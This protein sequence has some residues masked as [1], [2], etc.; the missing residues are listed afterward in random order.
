MKFFTGAAAFLAASASACM[1][2]GSYS[3][4]CLSS[5]F[6]TKQREAYLTY[7]SL[8]R[9]HGYDMNEQAQQPQMQHSQYS[10]S[11]Y[12]PGENP[13]LG[14]WKLDDGA[15]W[16][17]PKDAAR[18]KE[19]PVEV[20]T[21]FVEQVEEDLNVTVDVTP[22]EVLEPEVVNAN[23]TFA[24]KIKML[25]SLNGYTGEKDYT[26]Y[27][28]T[29][30]SYK[31]Y[32]PDYY[33]EPKY[34][35]SITI[36]QPTKAGKVCLDGYKPKSEYDVELENQYAYYA[37]KYEAPKYEEPKY[38]EPCYEPKY[39]KS[40]E[41]M[42]GYEVEQAAYVAPYQSYKQPKYEEPKYEAP[43]YEK[44]KYVKSYEPKTGYEV[45]KSAY[46]YQQ[47]DYGYQQDYGYKQQDYG[48]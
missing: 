27:M 19:H 28:S 13:Y 23:P 34:G 20:A 18:M 15:C 12:I 4:H 5:D 11:E 36:G 38:E 1:V 42:T 37:P 30:S 25:R 2:D 46:G 35:K 45:E 7:Y 3:C 6:Y 41:P 43:K 40:Y 44:P 31:N 21:E 24:D 32:K 22:N 14:R 39:V 33:K 8:M 17:S 47:P 10:F 9:S 26:Q 48:Y 29:A 16:I